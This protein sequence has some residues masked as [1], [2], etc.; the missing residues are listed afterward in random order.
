MIT[1]V[2]E[3]KF[4]GIRYIVDT[5]DGCYLVSEISLKI[6]YSQLPNEFE[7]S[8]KNF[9]DRYLEVSLRFEAMFDKFF[10][11]KHKHPV[12]KIYSLDE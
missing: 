8:S 12:V 9:S 11:K 2:K 6:P 3:G 7:I 10:N 1:A 4:E 5:Y